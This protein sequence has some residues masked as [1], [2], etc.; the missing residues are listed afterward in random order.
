MCIKTYFFWDHLSYLHYAWAKLFQ[1]NLY[2]CET[3]TDCVLFHK[4]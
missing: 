3:V 1:S 2:I 4:E